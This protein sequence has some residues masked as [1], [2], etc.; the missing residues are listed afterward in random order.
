MPRPFILGG[1]AAVPDHPLLPTAEAFRL[2]G[3]NT[4][5]ILFQEAVRRMTGLDRWASWYAPAEEIDAAGDV[6]IIPCSNQLGDHQEMGDLADRFRRTR[7]RMVAIGLGAQWGY[8]MASLPPVGE[9]T[10]AWVRLIAERS[11]SR[12]PNI[13]LRG[14]FSQRVME[15]LGLADRTVILGCPSLFLNP[16]PRLGRRIAERAAGGTRYIAV[17][18]GHPGW[19]DRGFGP[20]EVSLAALAQDSCGSYF[21]QEPLS[22][23][24]LAQ[25]EGHLLDPE[26]LEACRAA[27]APDLDAQEFL[28]WAECHMH[29]FFDATSWLGFTRRYDCVV[30]M[31]IH[32]VIAALSVGIP[33]LCIAHDSRTRELCETMAVPFVPAHSVLEGIDAE[34]V[35]D[36]IQEFDGDAFDANRLRLAS[37]AR[38]FLTDNDLPVSATF[39]Q[40]A[41][42][43]G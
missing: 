7:A 38:R 37:R 41:E 23:V 29:S 26:E 5:N 34:W 20:L 4:G 14:R 30:G 1:P 24:M 18:G 25:G 43:R 36:Q 17:A 16:D 13:A 15:E 32:G 19:M 11:P 42:G 40:L 28:D 21:V 2:T 12:A 3:M 31:R 10:R 35:A 39:S 27:I 33:A 9:G 6:G 8:D 22:A